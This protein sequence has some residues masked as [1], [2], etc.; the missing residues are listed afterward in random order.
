MSVGYDAARFGAITSLRQLLGPSFRGS[1]ALPGDPRDAPA[2]LMAVMMA[3]LALGGSQA[4]IA[5]GVG[6]F[7][8]LKHA[9]NFNPAIATMFSVSSGTTPVVFNWDD[10]NTAAVV[11]KRGWK[12]FIPARAVLGGFYAQAINRAAPHPAAARLWEEFLYSQA[13]AGG[14]NL[15]LEGGVHPVEQAAMA[16]DGAL[17]LGAVR[18]LPTIPG[19]P[20]VITAAQVTS[21]QRYVAEHWARTVG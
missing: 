4:S 6:F 18:A 13:P 7:G 10:L 17:N 16:A 21:A 2:A 11:H 19:L 5:A 3:N 9:G 8:A 1:V 20:A 14:Q 12:V 15:W